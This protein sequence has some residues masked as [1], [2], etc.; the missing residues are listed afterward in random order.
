MVEP[1]I[2]PVADDPGEKDGGGLRNTIEWVAIVVGAFAVALLVKTFLIQAF[3]IP[4][5]SMFPALTKN[6]RVLVNKLSY[7]LHDIN[8]GDLVVFERPPEEPDSA[9]RDL[10]KRV[11]ALEGETIEGRG[12]VIHIDGDPLEEPYLQPGVVADAGSCGLTRMV[13]PDGHVFVMGDNRGS[14]RDSRCFGAIHADLIVGRA[15][16]KVWPVFDF[17]LL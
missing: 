7:E 2:A 15:F 12:G 3:Y 4:S 16:V 14:S 9:V 10:I 8:R 11:I 6:D 5:E 17:E 13:I 1:D